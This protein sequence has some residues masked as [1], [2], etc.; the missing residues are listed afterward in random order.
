MFFIMYYISNTFYTQRGTK[1]ISLKEI[2]QN[3]ELSM[4]L[5]MLHLHNSEVK[6]R[7]G[8]NISKIWCVQLSIGHIAPYRLQWLL[9]QPSIAGATW[10]CYGGEWRVNRLMNLHNIG[11]FGMEEN[12][13]WVLE[14]PPCGT[15]SMLSTMLWW[16]IWNIGFITV[17][18][19]NEGHQSNRVKYKLIVKANIICNTTSS[20]DL[21][22]GLVSNFR[23]QYHS[24]GSW[25]IS[26]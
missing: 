2:V 18:G 23:D 7:Q 24:I 6:S 11:C 25:K 20:S 17:H 9:F 8:K 13:Q 15:Y 22:H 16:Q 10:M 5:G 4:Q 14:A 12:V 1:I 26:K 19:R 21:G 3:S